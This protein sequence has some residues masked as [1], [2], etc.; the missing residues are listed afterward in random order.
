MAAFP[1]IEALAAAPLE[2]VNELWSGLGYYR[3]CKFLHEAAQQVIQEHDGQLPGSV[4]ELLRVKGIGKY[5]AGAIASIAFNV[6]APAVDGNVERVLARLRPGIL[7]NREPARS[8]GA[9]AKV[10]EHLATELV[11]DIETPGDFNQA[12]MELGA[13]LCTPKNPSCTKCPVQGIC[14]TFQEA[15]SSALSPSEYAERYPVKDVSRKVKVREEIVLVCVVRRVSGAE[16]EYL[17][18]QRPQSGLLA[19]LWESPNVVLPVNSNTVK[20]AAK[21]MRIM[22]TYIDGVLSAVGC[23]GDDSGR[24]DAG[25]TNHVFS[26][27]RQTLHVQCLTVENKGKESGKLEDGRHFRWQS[28]ADI[29]DSAVATQMRKALKLAFEYKPATKSGT[30]RRPERKRRK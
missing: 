12:I 1:T 26:H 17:L 13:T 5:T 30:T 10:Y 22:D 3:R 25:Q 24:R 20:S 19:G 9:K 14:G 18:T 29:T 6:P 2:R 7:P 23:A 21:R 15:S 8:P 27:I 16:P 4:E 11:A 28:E